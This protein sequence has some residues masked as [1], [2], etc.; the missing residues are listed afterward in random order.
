MKFS[1]GAR[2]RSIGTIESIW[3]SIYIYYE[4]NVQALIFSEICAT[5]KK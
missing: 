3:V 1:E 4:S 2:I 5:A